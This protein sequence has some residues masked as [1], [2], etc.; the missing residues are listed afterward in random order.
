MKA[1]SLF[2]GVGGHDFG[3]EAAGF[4]T[5]VALDMDP[6]SCRTIR[7]PTRSS[8]IS[9]CCV[10]CGRRRFCSR[11]SRA[12]FIE[13]IDAEQGTRHGL[14]V[15]SLDAG[16]LGVPQ[17]R[18]RVFVI[19]SREAPVAPTPLGGTYPSM[20]VVWNLLLRM[21]RFSSYKSLGSCLRLA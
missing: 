2:S 15:R 9:K 3:F 20:W 7:V 17:L 21:A 1:V 10:T 14:A 19:G 13:A 11:T 12:S 16:E 5:V 4:E 8:N 18:E 6:M